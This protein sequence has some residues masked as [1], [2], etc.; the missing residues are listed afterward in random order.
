MTIFKFIKTGK[1]FLLL[2]ALFV[3]ITFINSIHP[4]EENEE[5]SKPLLRVFPIYRLEECEWALR[6][7]ICHKCIAKK[8][9]YA[10]KIYFHKDRP[11]R[12]HGCY[13]ESKGFYVLQ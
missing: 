4:E 10:Q 8:E 2:T 7:D 11:Y 12:E 3:F 1:G 13:T 5:V 9:K 6:F